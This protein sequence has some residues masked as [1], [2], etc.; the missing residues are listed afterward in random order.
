MPIAFASGTMPEIVSVTKWQ[1]GASLSTPSSD[2][3]FLDMLHMP[4]LDTH[5]QR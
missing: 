3:D 2:F 5:S 1:I 4:P